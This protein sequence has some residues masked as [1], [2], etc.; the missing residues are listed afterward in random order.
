MAAGISVVRGY[1]PLMQTMS[2]AVALAAA[3]AL[4]VGSIGMASASS[5][6]GR[7]HAS[8]GR[9]GENAA[10]APART[11]TGLPKLV[12]IVDDN[13]D[14]EISDRT[15]ERGRYK[16]VVRDSTKSHN[17][18]LY[19]NGKSIATTVRGTGRWVFRIRLAP[20]AYRVVCDPHFDDMEFDLIVS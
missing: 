19:G 13:R 2:G 1:R 8:P 17:W 18:H 5:H 6:A 11:T 15:P 4:V 20:G 14:I 7:A 3:G 9:V 16:I 12:G 10:L